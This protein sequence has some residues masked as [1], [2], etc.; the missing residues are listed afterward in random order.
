MTRTA[1]LALLA[2][3]ALV[4]APRASG[5]S[6]ANETIAIENARVV[7]V[8][9]PTLDRATVLVRDGKI[10]AVGASVDVPAGARRI[11]AAGLTVYPGMIDA[12]SQ[13]GL[14]EIGSIS[15]T[16]DL[17]ELGEYNPELYA[18]DAFNPNSELI[19]EARVAGVTTAVAAPQNGT[20]SGQPLIVDLYGFTVE[21]MALRRSVGF[22]T[23]FPTGVGAD[24][25]DF[26]TFS[27]RHS[28]DAEAKKAQ[29]KKLDEMRRLLDDA[30]AYQK[31]KAARAADPKLPPL[32]HDLKLEALQSALS[33]ELPLIVAAFD[34]RDIRRAVEF[35]AEQKLKMVLVTAGQFATGDAAAVAAYL[36]QHRVPVVIG[37]MYQL[38]QSEDDRY[39]LPQEVPGILAKAGVPFAFASFDSAQVRDLPYQAAMAVAY[40]T[41]SKE[42]AV[43]AVTLWPAQIWGVA[44]RVGSIEVGKYANLVVT[45]G[46]LLEPRTDVK[47]VLIEGH[48]VPMES[49]QIELYERFKDRNP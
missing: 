20:I 41:L 19:R 38:P 42:D 48:V 11:D 8:S 26:A 28:S 37:T 39:D 32:E 15:A 24:S 34:F 9:G 16:N 31:A 6:L 33:G 3:L 44:D 27:V 25:F 30:R 29:E 2:A 46:D 7:T 43:R 12:S 21:Q 36:A 22:T 1:A 23:T 5:S 14:L 35:C 45:T 13:L 4:G 49:R 10:A 47:Y 17:G 40:G 18:F